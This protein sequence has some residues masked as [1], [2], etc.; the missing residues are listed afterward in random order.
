MHSDS[1]KYPL[2]S[3][4]WDQEEFLALNRVIESGR[5]TMGQEVMEFEN[6]F[7]DYIGAKHAVMFNSGSSANLG[8]I[9]AARYMKNSA[10][11]SGSEVIVPAVSWSTTYYP[12][13][14]QE[15]VLSFVDIDIETLNI[16]LSKIEE[17]ITSQTRAIFAVNLL[18]NPC[19]LI[20]LRK[21]ANEKNLILLEDNCESLGAKT[22]GEFSGTFGLGGTFSTFFSHHISTME[23]GLVATND[24]VLDETMRSIRAH[25]WTRDLQQSNSVHDKSGD[26]WDDLYRFVLPGFNLRPLEMEGALGKTQLSKLSTFVSQRRHNAEYLIQFKDKFPNIQLQKETGESSWFGFSLILSNTLSGKRKELISLLN[27][28]GIQSRPIVAGN[29]ARNPVLKHLRHAQLPALTNADKVHFDGLFVGNH[30]YSMQTQIDL[31][32]HVLAEFEEKYA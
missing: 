5:F 29:F 17:A 3:T 30:H 18:G 27:E 2:A 13:H 1:V 4:T 23:G 26:E 21:F 20:A 11:E 15:L 10:L 25:G 8:L 22:D 24:S 31:L 19:D 6:Q 16:D 14:Q 9:A 32:V 12:I 7:A 28:Y